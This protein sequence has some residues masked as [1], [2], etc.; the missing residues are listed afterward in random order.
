[1]KKIEFNGKKI[2]DRTGERQGRLVALYPTKQVGTKIYWM[3]RCDCG[4]EKEIRADQ[5]FVSSNSTRATKSCGC[6]HAELN[7]TV[8][9]EALINMSTTH[10]M[11]KTRFYKIWKH[12]KSRCTNPKDPR[13]SSYGARGI[14]VCDEWLVFE[15]FMNDM[16]ESYNIH[17]EKYGEDNTSI[18][19]I[20]VNSNYCKNNCRWATELEQANNKVNTVYVLLESGELISIREYC[21]LTNLNY[22][23]CRYIYEQTEFYND[24]KPIPER[25]LREDNTEVNE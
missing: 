7:A 10:G 2:K 24:K 23:R 4:K 22:F 18:D 16:L 15:N 14:Q 20:D 21:R 1:M 3:F 8:R 17:C 13:Y 5:V 6:L 25:I 11:S 12:M 9:K 19:R